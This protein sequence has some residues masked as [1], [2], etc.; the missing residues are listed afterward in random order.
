MSQTT[1]KNSAPQSARFFV[2][3]NVQG[4]WMASEKG[5]LVI[6][7]FPLQREALRYALSHLH[8]RIDWSR[9]TARKPR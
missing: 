2:H 1:E 8:P 6:G 9:S 5:G 7:I 4:Y 3:Q